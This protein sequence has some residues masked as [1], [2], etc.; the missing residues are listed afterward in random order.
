MSDP[1]PTPITDAAPKLIKSNHLIVCDMIST[2][3]ART[4]ERRLVLADRKLKV[5]VEALETILRCSDSIGNAQ[6]EAQDALDRLQ[7]AKGQP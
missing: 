4:L 7:R 2:D 3:F 1:I 6:S 5:A